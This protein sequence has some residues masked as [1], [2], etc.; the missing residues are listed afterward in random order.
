MPQDEVHAAGS[1]LQ[2][3]LVSNVVSFA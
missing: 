3:W 1:R 2:V